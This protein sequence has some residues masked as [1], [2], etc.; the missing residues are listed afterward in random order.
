[1]KKFTVVFFLI[2]S[3]VAAGCIS[4]GNGK[5]SKIAFTPGTY[6]GSTMGRN[7]PMT[8]EI[9]VSQTQNR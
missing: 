4:S 3:V 7:G 6:Q 8:V 1:M 9:T 5:G 2:L